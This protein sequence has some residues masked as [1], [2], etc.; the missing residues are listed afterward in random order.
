MHSSCFI[1]SKAEYSLPSSP[2]LS[3]IIFA[4]SSLKKFLCHR[5]PVSVDEAA[6]QPITWN[7][8]IRDDLGRPLGKQ[9]YMLGS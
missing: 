6:R 8:H 5:F 3:S 4:W 1:F 2:L 9:G 7:D